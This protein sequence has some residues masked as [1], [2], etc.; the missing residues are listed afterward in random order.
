M[1]GLRSLV[2]VAV[3]PVGCASHQV[4]VHSDGIAVDR[5]GRERRRQRRGHRHVGHTTGISKSMRRRLRDRVLPSLEV[6]L[7]AARE[8]EQIA[9]ALKGFARPR[10]QRG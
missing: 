2:I 5:G 3:K 8:R 10:G 4:A 6:L 9:E 7:Q 1:T